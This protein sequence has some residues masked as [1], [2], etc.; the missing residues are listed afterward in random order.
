MTMLQDDDGVRDVAAMQQQLYRQKL[1][2]K[3]EED[4]NAFYLEERILALELGDEFTYDLLSNSKEGEVLS[5]RIEANILIR[6]VEA[7]YIGQGDVVAIGRHLTS[8]HR[9][10]LPFWKDEGEN[11]FSKL[12]GDKFSEILS[13]LQLIFDN[14]DEDGLIYFRAFCYAQ[15]RLDYSS[16]DDDSL[17]DAF[18]V[19]LYVIQLLQGKGMEDTEVGA[20]H[21]LIDEEFY[22]AKSEHHE[23]I[24]MNGE[25]LLW[26]FCTLFLKIGSQ[27]RQKKGLE[28]YNHIFAEEP[29]DGVTMKEE[30][31]V[32]R[33]GMDLR[34][35]SP[36]TFLLAYKMVL[37]TRQGLPLSMQ[38]AWL[39]AAHEFANRGLTVADRWGDPF[40]KY[41]FRVL[42][43]FWLPTAIVQKDATPY[44]FGE[45]KN[46]I[47]KAH[48]FKEESGYV[49]PNYK[50]WIAEQH[51][52]LLGKT[53]KA[54][55][56]IDDDMEITFPLMDCITFAPI[57]PKAKHQSAPSV[58]T[59][60]TP[61]CE[62][63]SKPLERILKCA[64]C[65]N[66]AYCS[67][68]CQV[69][70]WKNGHK[71]ECLRRRTPSMDRM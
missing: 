7:Y 10:L 16:S 36:V 49:F 15:H 17:L 1:Q 42:V 26:C 32:S 23:D 60:R 69:Q 38:E 57:L 3:L 71:Q 30:L 59:P 11:V 67:R 5:Q 63:C 20:L 47:R 37:D 56:V 54:F 40:F 41:I 62:S 29:F 18:C 51:E 43:V 4:P 64:K 68:K 21:A 39:Q 44:S 46:R 61:K 55:P 35:E 25:A 12:K 53:L 52:M 33:L 24:E 48:E 9:T 13:S 19:S 8:F 6:L 2:E 27:I 34:P 31:A 70:H 66:V 45:I 14:N 22:N 28:Y 65:Q 50:F 58:T